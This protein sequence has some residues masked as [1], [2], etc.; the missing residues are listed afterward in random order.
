MGDLDAYVWANIVSLCDFPTVQRVRQVNKH[1]NTLCKDINYKTIVCLTYND[2]H[3]SKKLVIKYYDTFVHWKFYEFDEELTFN[4]AVRD[5][6]EQ[7]QLLYE[8]IGHFD[9]LVVEGATKR[10][11]LEMIYKAQIPYKIFITNCWLPCR[12]YE[13][14]FSMVGNRFAKKMKDEVF[15]YYE[16]PYP[17]WL[18]IKFIEWRD[19]MAVI[20][21]EWFYG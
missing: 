16:Y 5:F 15:E 20:K 4:Y 19:D 2:W 7:F 9:E 3:T 10:E 6:L 11:A 13:D 21:F 1:L 12:T 8:F 17:Y 14:L 18:Y